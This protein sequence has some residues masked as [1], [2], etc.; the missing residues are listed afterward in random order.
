[1]MMYCKASPYKLSASVLDDHAI[2]FERCIPG[3][4]VHLLNWGGRLTLTNAVMSL[5]PV[6]AMGAVRLP[7]STVDRMD[8]P[9]FGMVWKGAPHCSGAW[10]KACCLKEEDGFG[11]VDIDTQNI[12]LLLKTIDKLVT[13]HNNPWA[14][15][16]CYW[17]VP[18]RRSP[19]TPS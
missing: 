10:T 4:H 18:G 5:K 13:G 7:R 8:K 19:P 12:C 3:W 14:N 2:P 11:I 16:V 15:W 9:R 6:Y 1:M 17:Y